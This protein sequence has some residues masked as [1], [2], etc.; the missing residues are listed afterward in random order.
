MKYTDDY[1]EVINEHYDDN[2]NYWRID[3]WKTNDENEEGKVVA[4]INGTTAEP[5]F[6]DTTARNDKK[7]LEAIRRRQHW[8][9]SKNAD[10]K[11][12]KYS[13]FTYAAFTADW[14]MDYF[15]VNNPRYTLDQALA[16]FAG[17]FNLEVG[18]RIAVTHA[19]VKYMAYT[20]EDGEK[21]TGWCLSY[22]EI[23]GSCPV[24]AFH[25]ASSD[26]HRKGYQ[27]VEV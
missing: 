8:I 4:F 6:T 23:K 9:L 16:L 27:Y 25:K 21:R 7:V 10:A 15:A 22:N 19:Y 17:E 13:T 24:W 2:D 5:V 1:T 14:D 3:A 11:Q 12:P 20:D 26:E 18:T